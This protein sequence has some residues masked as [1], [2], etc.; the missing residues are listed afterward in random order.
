MDR[1]PWLE[2]DTLSQQ[3]PGCNVAHRRRVFVD[4]TSHLEPPS[5]APLGPVAH[6]VSYG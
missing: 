3:S 2:A 4:P 6:P 1:V 5:G